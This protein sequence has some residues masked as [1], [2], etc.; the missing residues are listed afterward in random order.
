MH[1][2]AMIGAGSVTFA[3]MLVNDLLFF[4]PFRDAEFSLMDID[5]DRLGFA[6]NTLSLVNEVRKA[7]ATFTT[8]TDRRKAL[9]GADFVIT[10]IQVGGTDAIRTD[11]EVC[12]RHGIRFVIGDSMGVPGVSR[13]LRTIP[14]LLD[15]AH[16]MEEVCPNAYLLNYANPM[17]MMMATLLRDSSTKAIGLCHG[18]FG[19][20]RTL[21]RFIDVPYDRVQYFCAGI[22]HLAF[23]LRYEVDGEDA[24]PLI[25]R[26]FDTTHRDQEI[27]RQEMFRRLGYFM[28]ESSYHL[29]EY[30]PYFI[31]SDELIREYDVEVDEN[32]VKS[33]ET[34]EIFELVHQ[35][36]LEGRNL[37]AEGGQVTFVPRSRMR[38][39]H[40]KP[41]EEFVAFRVPD[42]PSGEYCSRI[43]NAIVTGEAYAFH[44]N[45]L[46]KGLITNLPA[47]TCVEVP[48]LVDGNG[49]QPTHV[50]ELPPQCAAV[51]QT[52]LNVQELTTRG[53]L[54]QNRDYVYHAVLLS[55]LA[56]AVL[57][58][59]GIYDLM[60]D[61]LDAHRERVPAWCL[62]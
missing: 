28:T 4:D 36:F 45:V 57:S 20:A 59:R 22:N 26:A 60:D 42:R 7:N 12:R 41:G 25:R 30:L 33:V 29:P 31:K 61:L 10:M 49:F 18:V 2:I 9:E 34:A 52:N 56:S 1:K 38:R 46:N 44:G 14:A 8:T 40:T 27:V 16:A 13:A 17:G 53:M 58:T 35:A 43:C 6:E 54:E 55:P 24:Y 62:K 48:C 11:F 19:T 50:G 32:L 21:A 39:E 47:K 5:A 3:R 37:L 51:I 15:I 23:F